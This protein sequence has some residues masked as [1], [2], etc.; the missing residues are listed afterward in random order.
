MEIK[1]IAFPSISTGVFGY[2]IM[3]ASKIS[4]NEV[5]YFLVINPLAKMGSLV[6]FSSDNLFLFQSQ[7]Q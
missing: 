4:L 2:P 7:L 3:Q 5:R 6:C 1:F